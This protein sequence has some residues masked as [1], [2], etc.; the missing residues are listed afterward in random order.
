MKPEIKSDANMINIGFAEPCHNIKIYVNKVL[1]YE[2]E[3]NKIRF[4]DLEV[5]F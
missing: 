5:V 1:I 4:I 2:V 3:R